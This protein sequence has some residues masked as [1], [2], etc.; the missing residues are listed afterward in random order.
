MV[1]DTFTFDFLHRTCRACMNFIVFH[2]DKTNSEPTATSFFYYYFWPAV[3]QSA[4][5]SI[6]LSAPFASC[7]TCHLFWPFMCWHATLSQAIF[8]NRYGLLDAKKQSF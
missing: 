2:F 6:G 3:Y 5:T 4:S 8:Y 7:M 1:E